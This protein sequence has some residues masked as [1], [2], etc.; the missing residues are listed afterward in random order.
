MC[1]FHK[2]A[3]DTK[4]VICFQGKR[5]GVTKVW[6]VKKKGFLELCFPSLYA[7]VTVL[8]KKAG[9]VASRQKSLCC[10]GNFEESEPLCC[11]VGDQQLLDWSVSTCSK[12]A[13]L[14]YFLSSV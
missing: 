2:L 1:D 12:S 10:R 8:S 3:R 4:N 11:G 6:G 5:S 9:Y 14:D 13:F 7:N